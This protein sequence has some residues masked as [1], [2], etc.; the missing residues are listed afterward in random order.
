MNEGEPHMKDET[1]HTLVA[2][3]NRGRYALSDPQWQDISFRRRLHSDL[4]S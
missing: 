3:S 2:S 1:I 4:A